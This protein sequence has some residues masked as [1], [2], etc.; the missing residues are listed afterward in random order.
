MIINDL[1]Q[2]VIGKLRQRTE[3]AGVAPYYIAQTILDLT[4]NIEFEELKV[5]GPLANFV[6]NV[7]EYPIKGYD[8]NGI[9]GNPFIN[10]EDHR[11]TFVNSW[12]VYFNTSGVPTPGVDTGKNINKRD[13]LVVE[14]MSKILGLP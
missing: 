11:I 14:P 7:A 6:A 10:A 13:L 5:T 1:V 4:E 3:Y 12:F 8:V 2:P 9:T